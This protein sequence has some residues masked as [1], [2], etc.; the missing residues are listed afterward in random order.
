MTSE[1]ERRKARAET[2]FFK[3]VL[4]RRSNCKCEICS[5]FV[6]FTLELHHIKPISENGSSSIENVIVLCPNCHRTVHKIRTKMLADNPYFEEW[7]YERYGLDTG[8]KL[9]ELAYEQVSFENGN[10]IIKN[11]MHEWGLS[12]KGRLPPPVSPRG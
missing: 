11:K 2:L 9:I 10:L 1:K 8:Q 6:P 7:I 5:D 3:E 12:P 4:L